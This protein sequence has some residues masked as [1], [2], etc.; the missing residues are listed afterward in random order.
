MSTDA[1]IHILKFG[2][3]Q[4]I[5]GCTDSHYFDS[6]AYILD[7]DYDGYSRE[8]I[9]PTT[10]ALALA[11]SDRLETTQFDWS[12]GYPQMWLTD[13][14]IISM[15]G[16]KQT[17]VEE[18]ER[19]IDQQY[20][21]A[22][23]SDGIDVTWELIV[24]QSSSDNHTGQWCDVTNE[25]IYAPTCYSCGAKVEDDENGPADVRVAY[26]QN[27]N[28]DGYI[29]SR[30][31]AERICESRNATTKI[32]LGTYR[33]YDDTQEYHRPET[34]GYQVGGEWVVTGSTLRGTFRDD[35]V[36]YVSTKE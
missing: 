10:F 23:V 33:V 13:G 14:E 3:K 19:A 18:L 36:R 26:L 16:M 7:I 25:W 11:K 5:L 22:H 2:P 21:T 35:A 1:T 31:V 4:A 12:F 32:D 6:L 27:T 29:C 9:V 24:D 20:P 28:G 17:L 15:A 30:C 34:L 8:L